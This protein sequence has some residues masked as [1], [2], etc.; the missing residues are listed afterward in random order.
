MK[1]INFIETFLKKKSQDYSGD[2]YAYQMGIAIFY[3]DSLINNIISPEQ[4][5]EIMEK[6]INKLS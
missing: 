3:L 2:K 1:T 5:K 4:L 6:E